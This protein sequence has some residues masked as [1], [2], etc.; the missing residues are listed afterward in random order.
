MRATAKTSPLG[1]LPAMILTHVDITEP[2][3][4]V[5]RVDTGGLIQRD[6]CANA[7]TQ[8]IGRWQAPQPIARRTVE[9]AGRLVGEQDRWGEEQ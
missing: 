8:N 5:G 9:G 7:T 1:K 2:A 4:H 6:H 3:E